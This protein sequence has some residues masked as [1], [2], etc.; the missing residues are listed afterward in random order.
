MLFLIDSS[1]KV[2]VKTADDT[3]TTKT[4]PKVIAL[5]DPPPAPNGDSTA[6]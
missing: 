4:Y 6:Q 5:V 1:G 2:I 3:A